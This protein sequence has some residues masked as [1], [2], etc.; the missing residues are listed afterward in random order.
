M[1]SFNLREL[2]YPGKRGVPLIHGQRGP[3]LPN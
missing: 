1:Q 2:Y 3:V